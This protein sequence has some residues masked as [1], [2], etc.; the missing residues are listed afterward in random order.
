MNCPNCGKEVILHKRA[1]KNQTV[2]YCDENCER[3]FR[4]K[5]NLLI[6]KMMNEHRARILAKQAN[7][8]ASHDQA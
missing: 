4:A 6:K 8:E 7:K 5:R 2:F 3:E 1:P